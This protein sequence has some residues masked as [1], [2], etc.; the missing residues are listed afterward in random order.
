MFLDYNQNAKDRTIAAAYS[1]RPKPDARVSAPL[2]WDEIGACE[3]GDFTLAT[4][5]DRFKRVHDPHATMDQQACSIE[6]LLELSRR[7][8]K[9]GLGDAPWPPHYVKQADEPP[10][11]QPSR[12][13]IPKRPLIEIGRAEK[14]DDALAGLE[15][16][17]AR[18]P[19]AAAHLQPADVLVDAMRGRFHTWTRIRVNLQ[20]VPEE[21]RP[22]IPMEATDKGRLT[23]REG[24]RIREVERR[25]D[26]SW[27]YD[28]R[29]RRVR[30]TRA[31]R[32]PSVTR[33]VPPS[34]R[35]PGAGM[36]FCGR[37]ATARC[38]STV[39]RESMEA[40]TCPSRR[41]FHR[42]RALPETAAAP[43]ARAAG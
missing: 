1:V 36:G 34:Q 6:G 39:G 4:M 22:R 26:R 24:Q 16:W 31:R 32:D 25:L 37:S 19:E 8:A 2:S 23:A 21:L 15:R 38:R 13:R 12:R 27:L 28:L 7:H 3:P 29:A 9:E 41:R 20:H 33:P 18:H 40:T 5:P 43:P 14:K 10:R 17:R 11:V 42:D 35:G 30:S